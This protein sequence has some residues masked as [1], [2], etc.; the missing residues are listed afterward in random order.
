MWHA[1]HAICIM[2]TMS[3]HD[4]SRPVVEPISL[5]LSRSE[6]ARQ[7]SEF[8]NSMGTTHDLDH[9][10]EIAQEVAVQLGYSQYI[11]IFRAAH[12]FSLLPCMYHDDVKFDL[13][14]GNIVFAHDISFFSTEYGYPLSVLY[15]TLVEKPPVDFLLCMREP[16]F[17]DHLKGFGALRSQRHDRLAEVMLAERRGAFHYARCSH[18]G[19]K[20]SYHR[21][22]LDLPTILNLPSK[23]EHDFFVLNIGTDYLS[24]ND[25]T[26]SLFNGSR[27][28]PHISGIF[29]EPVGDKLEQTKRVIADLARE[30]EK[31]DIVFVQGNVT[32]W[33]VIDII[34][35]ARQSLKEQRGGGRTQI[36]MIDFL[37]INGIRGMDMHVVTC[38]LEHTQPMAISVSFEPHLPFFFRRS[39][40]I[41]SGHD[42]SE[43]S[44]SK[45]TFGL[46]SLDEKLQTLWEEA[47]FP[48]LP[49]WMDLLSNNYFLYK[50]YVNGA[51]KII[52]LRKDSRQ[53]AELRS[54]GVAWPVDE[55]ACWLTL[56]F[57]RWWDLDLEWFEKTQDANVTQFVTEYVSSHPSRYFAKLGRLSEWYSVGYTRFHA[58]NC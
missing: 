24:S 27:S 15:S 58:E 9:S 26:Y 12:V 23:D 32:P 19:A 25:D 55:A 39:Y 49:A 54:E 22:R 5:V 1:A 45:E 48:S 35:N 56:P 8:G 29:V 50:M 33:T 2:L 44:R 47:F 17:A 40:V 13:H 36:D 6:F 41:P 57:A 3:E 52:F 14:N 53:V 46:S 4:F 31:R 34:E 21:N 42:N 30:D 20:D 7:Y 51:P 38:I 28:I 16:I 18:V 10:L 37:K 11:W 43:Q